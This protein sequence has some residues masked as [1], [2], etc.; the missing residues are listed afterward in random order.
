MNL[1]DPSDAVGRLFKRVFI[2]QSRAMVGGL[3]GLDAPSDLYFER[4][5]NHCVTRGSAGQPAWVVTHNDAFSEWLNAV[6]QTDRAY[7]QWRLAAHDLEIQA[8]RRIAA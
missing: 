6:A 3:P 5:L 4:C 2:L 7:C 1:S 8:S